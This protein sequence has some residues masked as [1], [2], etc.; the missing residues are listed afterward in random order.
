M[1]AP[2]GPPQP[3]PARWE[4]ERV[5]ETTVADVLA[6]LD[7]RYPPATAAD[8]DAV[9]LVCGDPGDRATAVRFAVDPVLAVVE[10]AIADGVQLLVTHHPLLLRPVTGVPTTD[11]R[12]LVVSRLLRAG[13]A[14]V[15]AHTNADV[16][17]PGVSDALAAAVGLVGDLQ[18]LQPDHAPA[19]DVLAVHVPVR[20][21]AALRAAL[22]AA[23]AGA[24]GEYTEASFSVDGTGRFRPGAGARPALGSAGD[25]AEVAESR[26]E[27]VLPRA[28]RAAV[29]AAMRAAHPYEEVAFDLHELAPSPGR[30]GL[31]RVGE[32]AA[33]LA[34]RTFADR[35]AAALPATPAGIRWAGDPDRPVRRVAVSGGSGDSVL[36][37][38]AAAGAD[39]VVTADLRH[40]P[41]SGFLQPTSPDRVRPALIEPTHWASEWPWL[42]VAARL[43]G[44]DLRATGAAPRVDVSALVTDP[45]NGTA[46]R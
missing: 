30:T 6:A 20:D 14:L 43:L 26:V 27:V 1:V 38:A 23:G 3:R 19:L 34:L 5:A 11:P 36:P 40:H 9:G 8:W 29:L 28:R 21:G 15:V 31:G 12:G 39:V 24:V 45:W 25:L 4:G 10:E 18:P 16:A 2:S 32:L 33:P 22:A 42:P 17:R 37:A 35:V 46:G 7:A 44:E 41:V 13:V